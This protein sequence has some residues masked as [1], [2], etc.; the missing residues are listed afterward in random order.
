[1][2]ALDSTFLVDYL[3][4]EPATREFLASH[5]GKPF[6]VPSLALF[7]TY[8]GAAK[9]GGKASVSRVATGLDWTMPLELNTAAAREAAVIEAELLEDGTPINIGDV[10]IAGIC[11]QN[12]ASLF[13]RD[14]HFE[15]V[16]DLETISY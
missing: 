9:T 12:G 3:N 13:T 14:Q 15:A 5:E 6:F 10:L 2:I 11:R 1:M 8:R 4:G 7:E 16:N